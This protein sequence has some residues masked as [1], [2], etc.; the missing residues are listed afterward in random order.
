MFRN[1]R[2]NKKLSYR[3]GIAWC[4]MS[5]D[6]LSAA[7]QLHEN[8]FCINNEMLLIFYLVTIILSISAMLL[9]FAAIIG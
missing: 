8:P 9:I 3:R 4:V 1:P 7:M 2:M 5:V 6:V